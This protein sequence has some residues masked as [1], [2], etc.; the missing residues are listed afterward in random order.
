ME[1]IQSLQLISGRNGIF[2]SSRLNQ[3]DNNS[4]IPRSNYADY[5]ALPNYETSKLHM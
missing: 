1:Q 4:I 3:V 5:F 2:G